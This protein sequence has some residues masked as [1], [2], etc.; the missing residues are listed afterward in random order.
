MTTLLTLVINLSMGTMTAAGVA[1]LLKHR[2]SFAH[3]RHLDISNNRVDALALRG[4][5][6]ICAEVDSDDQD[7][8]RRYAAVG[9]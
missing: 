3:L 2:E 8:G 9:E 1:T 4:V 6:A 7:V 5:E